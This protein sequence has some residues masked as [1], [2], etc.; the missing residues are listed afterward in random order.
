MWRTGPDGNW[1]RC[2]GRRTIRHTLKGLENGRDGMG[3]SFLVL[4]GFLRRWGGPKYVNIYLD[5]NV[6]A[7]V[8]QHLYF[9]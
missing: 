5:V 7:Y 3:F 6:E 2:A 8:L 4:V 1:C 9:Y